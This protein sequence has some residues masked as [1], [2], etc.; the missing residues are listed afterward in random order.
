M[1]LAII[2]AAWPSLP[3]Q[4]AHHRQHAGILSLADDR[5]IVQDGMEATCD[6]GQ[7]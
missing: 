5:R 2:A 3:L 6:N 4:P 1:Q 7:F